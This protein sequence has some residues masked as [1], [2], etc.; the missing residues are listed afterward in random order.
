VSIPNAPS[1]PHII[2]AYG[3]ITS[4]AFLTPQ[5]FTV[6]PA[7]T[8]SRSSGSPGSQ[9]T[10]TGSGF[11]SSESGITVTYDGNP[12]GSAV[13]ATA[14]GN[15]SVTLSIPPST[16]GTHSIAAVGPLTTASS[17]NPLT[18]TVS[19]TIAV[20]R[21]SGPPGTQVTVSGTG[22][23]TG[24]TGITITFDGSPA[25]AA[26]PANAMGA[27]SAPSPSLTPPPALIPSMLT[28]PPPRQVLFQA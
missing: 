25:G 2:S 18:F 10:V 15:W 17:T 7:I 26:P 21:T 8:M 23:A 20:N 16:S 11:A 13:S 3:T 14:L 1:G 22:F 19:S 12:V 9:V 5:T 24:E 28:A 6:N 4:A 27:W